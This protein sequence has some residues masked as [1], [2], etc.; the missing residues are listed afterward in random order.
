MKKSKILL[1]EDDRPTIDIY[2]TAFEFSGFDIDIVDL[3]ER[4]IDT[5]KKIEEGKKLPPD[6]IMLD[7]ILPDMS[8]V[9]ILKEIKKGE[10]TKKI[11][12]FVFSNY[13]D[14]ELEKMDKEKKPD[15]IILKTNHSPMEIVE[16]V[17]KGIEK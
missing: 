4:A 13:A 5:V 7:L 17:K 11:P 2:K 16:M 8:G 12:V 10:K 9:D 14:S 1:I 3:G 15:K 6:L